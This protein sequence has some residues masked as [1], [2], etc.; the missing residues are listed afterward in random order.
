MSEMSNPLQE[1]PPADKRAVDGI[2]RSAAGFLNAQHGRLVGAVVWMLEHT[3]DWQGD[4]LW[5]PEAYVR[6]RTGVGPA[7]AS[8]VA[9][10]ARRA[11]EFPACIGA[12]QRGELSLD[13]VTPIVRHAPGWCDAQMAELAPKCTVQQISKIAREYAWGAADAEA[14]DQ[15]SDAADAQAAPA[16]PDAPRLEPADEAWFGW[17]DHG[18]FRL[19][20]DVGADTGTLLEAALAEC[21]DSQFRAGDS[22]VDTVD[23]FVEMAHRSFDAVAS[24]D[25]RNRYRVN[26]HIDRD[27]RPSDARRRPMRESVA[28]R[29]TCD[30]LLSPVAWE[31]EIPVSVGRT[32]HIV[33]DR[34]RRIV[35]HRDGGCR[36]PGCFTDRFVEVHHIV[37][38]SAGGAT[39]TSNLICL[40]PRH[41]RLHHQGR[42][43]IVGDADIDNGVEFTDA[44]G[45]VL[46]VTGSRPQPLGAPP[47]PI[48][49]TW[50]H[51][52]GE[53]LDFRWLAFTPPRSPS[54]S[55]SPPLPPSSRPSAQRPAPD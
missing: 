43:G 48:R 14:P 27:G 9:D 26:I 52:L 23:A 31:N 54:R 10:V 29:I 18:R 49:G 5:T 28:D 25:R 11:G 16:N 7:T 39:D 21:R 51:P 24:A 17:D 6:W 41:H 34:T 45:A 22:S 8:K 42:L 19:H 35:E 53:R 36:T 33:P 40:C 20:A 46:G 30:A 3:R 47:P 1:V 50:R 44:N 4:G 32:R 38:W 13:Q 12:L 2:F 55:P 37:H 15:V